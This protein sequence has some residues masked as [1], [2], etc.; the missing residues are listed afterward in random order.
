M[1]KLLLVLLCI[2][3]LTDAS[4]QECLLAGNPSF[5]DHSRHGKPPKGWYDCGFP[6]ET[7]PDVLPGSFF[8]VTLEPYDGKSYLGMVV[9]DNSTWESVSQRTLKTLQKDSTYNLSIYLARSELYISV[10]RVTDEA[11]NYNEPAILRIWGGKGYCDKQQLLGETAP[12]I[13]HEWE[14][15]NFTFRPTD[16]WRYITLEAYYDPSREN[17]PYCGNILLDKACLE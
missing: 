8:N 15:Y 13:N 5:E 9:R 3:F 17:A 11:I 6:R 16:D 2:C 12:I 10:S 7:P 14:E 1:K 4:A